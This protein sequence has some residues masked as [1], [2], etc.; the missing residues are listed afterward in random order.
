MV[1]AAPPATVPGVS[2]DPSRTKSSEWL[3]GFGNA[4]TLLFGGLMVAGI[5][6]LIVLGVQQLRRQLSQVSLES[7]PERDFGTRMPAAVAETKLSGIQLNVAPPRFSLQLR[8]TEPSVRPSVLPSGTVTSAR[9]VFPERLGPSSSQADADLSSITQESVSEPI[10][11]RSSTA[12]PPDVPPSPEEAARVEPILRDEEHISLAGSAERQGEV[13]ADVSEAAHAGEWVDEMVGEP[14]VWSPSQTIPVRFVGGPDRIARNEE[15]IIVEELVAEDEPVT[16]GQPIPQLTPAPFFEPV[17]SE[18]T[19]SKPESTPVIPETA[20]A[21]AIARGHAPQS[22]V[23]TP[24][25]ASKIISTQT[26]QPQP[27]TPF[28][29]PDTT[30]TPASVPTPAPVPAPAARPTA[31]GMAVQQPAGGMHTAVQLTFSLEIASMQLTPTFKMSGLQLKPTSRVVTMRLAPSQ[32]PQPPMNLQV[33]FEVAG[34]ELV[35]GSIGTVRLSPSVQEKPAVLTSSSFAITGL[36]LM[37]TAGNAPVQLTPTHQE[38]A[39]VHMT[40]AFQIAA[41][42]FSP[43][44]E[45]VTIVLKSTSRNVSMQLPGSGPSSIDSA[46]IFEIET[47]QLGAAGELAAIQVNPMG[48]PNRRA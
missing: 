27:R 16:Q 8:A 17:M 23:E 25:F 10:I 7:T 26:L 4:R 22:P 46:P 21:A 48:G 38:Q 37:A 18:L 20:A 36:E 19:E 33:T 30:I 11:I 2:Q 14:E 40:A 47:V 28:N 6:L 43:A 35:G 5:V 45:I 42:E 41:I 29:M 9:S 3:E 1:R 44:F 13:S 15:P 32:H 34:I 39:S 24:S 12:S 31:P